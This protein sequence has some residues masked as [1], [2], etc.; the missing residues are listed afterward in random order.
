MEGD[1][2]RE[3]GSIVCCAPIPTRHA[4]ILG[5]IALFFRQTIFNKTRL[6]LTI[7]QAD[8]W[9]RD[10]LFIDCSLPWTP[11]SPKIPSPETALVYAGTA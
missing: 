11:P 5:E 3:T 7:V 9:F 8:N 6:A 4:M 10:H 2:A 1:I